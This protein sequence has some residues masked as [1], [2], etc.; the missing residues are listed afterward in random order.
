MPDNE[1]QQV[2]APL[3]AE[4][5]HKHDQTFVFRSADY[6]A[7]ERLA[8]T[9]ALPGDAGTTESMPQFDAWPAL[10]DQFLRIASFADPPRASD[11]QFNLSELP[12]ADCHALRYRLKQ[13]ASV[14]ERITE[15][16]GNEFQSTNT[17]AVPPIWS[18][19]WAMLIAGHVLPAYIVHV[20][21][22]D[23]RPS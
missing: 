15:H 2:L 17:F 20:S 1:S 5:L 9:L 4:T 19:R 6:L 3:S 7:L 8:I 13:I 21:V 18:R 10:A 16:R 14:L 23:P 12:E 11:L 22:G